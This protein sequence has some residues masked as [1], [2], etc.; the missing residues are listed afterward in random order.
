MKTEEEKLTNWE[1]LSE[2]YLGRTMYNRKTLLK[3]I[4]IGHSEDGTPIAF[5]SETVAYNVIVNRYKFNYKI[6]RKIYELE[7]DPQSEGLKHAIG[8]LKQEGF[9]Y[10]DKNEKY[11]GV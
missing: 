2:Y 3:Y 5:S 10:F 8:E 11:I 9:F 4:V 1:D 7:N 6:Y